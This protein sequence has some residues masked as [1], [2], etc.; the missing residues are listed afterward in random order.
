MAHGNCGENVPRPLLSRSGL[1]IVMVLYGAVVVLLHVD[2]SFHDKQ[3]CCLLGTLCRQKFTARV[4][5]MTLQIFHF[6]ASFMKNNN[7]LRLATALAFFVINLPGVS[8][9]IQTENSMSQ[10]FVNRFLWN[11]AYAGAEGNR[12]YAMQNRS[13]I[14]FDGAP[15]LTNITG[16]FNFGLNSSAGVHVMAD[17][18]GILNRTLGVF[19]YAYNI[20]FHEGNALRLG[21]SFSLSSDRLDY[22]KLGDAAAH[23]PLVVENVNSKTL[24]D[25]NFGA[26]YMHD[27]L[28]IAVSVFRLAKNLKGGDDIANL[29]VGQAAIAYNIALDDQGKMLIKP[30]VV[31]RMY[32]KT[33]P[34]FDAGFEAAYDN[35]FKVMGMYQTT[36][37]IRGGLGIYKV[38]LGGINVMYSTNHKIANTASQQYEVGLMVELGKKY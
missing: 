26:V 19:T 32:R 2:D 30:M 8:A 35:M 25:G 7:Y 34:V 9:Q 37:N 15:V 6:Q 14:G 21:V 36:G 1:F 18:S 11:P 12:I 10:Y 20:Q 16:E 23:D 5:E 27:N 22:S 38:G 29:A 24:Y 3:G 28:D 33:A 31:G 13:W 4:A 17:K